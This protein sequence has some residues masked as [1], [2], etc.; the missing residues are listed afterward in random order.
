MKKTVFIYVYVA[1]SRI[2][3]FVAPQGEGLL[4]QWVVF[5][6][7]TAP[8][9]PSKIVFQ[10]KTIF[11]LPVLSH[12]AAHCCR[13]CSVSKTD[14]LSLISAVTS[15]AEHRMATLKCLIDLQ[16]TSKPDQA[17]QNT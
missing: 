11:N 14:V 17:N 5:L 4:R 15:V 12:P 13:I 1:L 7:P 6:L 16:V 10:P 3:N 8:T 2:L 9:M